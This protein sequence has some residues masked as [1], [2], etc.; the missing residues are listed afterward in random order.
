M[1]KNH[2]LRWLRHCF[3]RSKPFCGSR[4]CTQMTPKKNFIENQEG[5]AFLVSSGYIP[6]DFR[7]HY[8]V[9]NVH[10]PTPKLMFLS[11]NPP[12]RN[13]QKWP[14]SVTHNVHV[15]KTTSLRPH[16]MGVKFHCCVLLRPNLKRIFCYHFFQPCATQGV[17]LVQPV[18]AHHA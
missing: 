15:T 7:K 12:A 17:R 5:S 2:I 1:T 10:I 16:S 6:E 13:S 18:S 3:R 11:R 9:G 14:C 4:Q 8:F